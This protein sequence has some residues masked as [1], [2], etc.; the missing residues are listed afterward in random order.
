MLLG[1]ASVKAV[2][3]KLMKLSPGFHI[4]EMLHKK[5]VEYSKLAQTPD[6]SKNNLKCEEMSQI[7]EVAS[8]M[9]ECRI[10]N[11]VTI[12]FVSKMPPIYS[13]S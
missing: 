1:S 4:I 6:R 10:V 7:L 13:I 8:Q 11:S 9:T 12:F 5:V 3:R 2:C